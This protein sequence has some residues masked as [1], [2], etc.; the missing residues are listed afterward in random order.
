M[1]KFFATL[2]LMTSISFGA[3]AQLSPVRIWLESLFTLE[4]VSPFAFQKFTEELVAL[5]FPAGFLSEAVGT[6]KSIKVAT[7]E[8]MGSA[9]AIFY[10][11]PNVLVVSS[12]IFNSETKQIRS[13]SE[14]GVVNAS[15]LV[16]ELWHGYFW[17]VFRKTDEYRKFLVDAR[18]IYTLYPLR[19]REEIHEESYGLYIQELS[20]A[21]LSTRQMLVNAPSPDVRDRLRRHPVVISNYQGATNR[22]VYGYYQGKDLTFSKIPLPAADKNYINF[23]LIKWNLSGQFE[24]DFADLF[25]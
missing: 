9:A 25:F 22:A 14:M 15:V 20:R 19:V 18:A 10:Q 16:H 21:V 2:L 7:P 4:S 24:I 5:K 23:F 11:G 1:S 13:I 17:S 3:Y 8:Q 12:D 6:V